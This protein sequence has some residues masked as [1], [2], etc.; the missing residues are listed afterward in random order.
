MAEKDEVESG[1]KA[2]YKEH[3]WMLHLAESFCYVMAGGFVFMM[4]LIF[5]DQ[6]LLWIPGIILGINSVLNVIFVVLLRRK[7]KGGKM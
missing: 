2:I 7:A 6:S 4:V 3:P 1:M 5:I